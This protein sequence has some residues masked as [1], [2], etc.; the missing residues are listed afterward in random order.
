MAGKP[1]NVRAYGFRHRVDVVALDVDGAERRAPVS[2]AA[3]EGVD[4]G[5]EDPSRLRESRTNPRL[6]AFVRRLDDDLARAFLS[7]P[8]DEP[9]QHVLFREAV[10]PLAQAHRLAASGPSTLEIASSASGFSTDERS[11]GSVPRAAALTARRT[12]FA[13]RVFGSAATNTTRSGRKAFPRT[14]LTR[15]A[16]SPARSAPPSSPAATQT[17]QA[18][19]PFTSCG[20]PIAAASTTRGCETAADSSS[21]GPTRFP[22]IFSVSSERPWRNQ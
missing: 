8:L 1:R 13:L 12:I 3:L 5:R 7:G 17:S 20:T 9:L 19:S 10:D 16:T 6:A 14:S 2:Q 22:A 15:S 4:V 21:A 11:P 18:T